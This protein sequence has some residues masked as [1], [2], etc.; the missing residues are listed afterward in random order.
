M[1]EL[2]KYIQN[3]SSFITSLRFMYEFAKRVQESEIERW[4]ESICLKIIGKKDQIPAVCFSNFLFS[5]IK[6]G[7]QFYHAV[8]R[9]DKKQRKVFDKKKRKYSKSFLSYI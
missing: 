2:N 4:S 7:F 6:K 5:K 1:S 3:C 8:I 9:I